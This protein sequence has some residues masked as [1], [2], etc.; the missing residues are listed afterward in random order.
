M[1]IRESAIDSSLLALQV[2]GEVL[3][4][5]VLEA[6]GQSVATLT[7]LAVL[8]KEMFQKHWHIT[9]A[10]T[11]PG[12]DQVMGGEEPAWFRERYSSRYELSPEQRRQ[13]LELSAE[14]ELSYRGT[15]AKTLPGRYL[16]AGVLVGL[17]TGII[18][19]ALFR[20]DLSFG[21]G[22]VGLGLVGWGL[23]ELSVVNH[24]QP[25]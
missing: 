22:I 5:P 15:K 20:K 6:I 21:T 13:L 4:E 25:Q 2:T 19:R 24:D 17:G 11:A 23:R 3:P 7:Y 9:G 18:T 10:T 12:S 16:R 14:F 8:T 1:L